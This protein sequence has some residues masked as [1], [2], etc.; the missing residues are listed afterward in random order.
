MTQTIFL[1]IFAFLILAVALIGWFLFDVRKKVLLLFGGKTTVKEGELV[2]DAIRRL[3]KTEIKLEELEPRLMLVEALSKISV[4]KVGFLRFNPFQDT[5]GDNSFA[6]VLLDHENNG[7]II[8]SFYTRE[9]VRT[10]GKSVEGGK[11]KHPLSEEEKKVLDE[12]VAK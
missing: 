1:T 5:G 4:Q 12:A 11:S 3:T 6:L 8:S 10:Y 2:H 7:V 9:G